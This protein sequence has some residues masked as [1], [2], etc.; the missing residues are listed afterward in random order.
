MSAAVA[1]TPTVQMSTDEMFESLTGFDEV[2]IAKHFGDE[3]QGLMTEKPVMFLRALA[4]VH[5]TR[6]EMNTADAKKAA[7][8]LTVKQAHDF[9]E[10]EV[11]DGEDDNPVTAQGKD[12]TAAG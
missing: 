3:W 10:P 12:D 9:F 1:N 7:M 6:T 5:F 8:G 11:E 2:A 4:F